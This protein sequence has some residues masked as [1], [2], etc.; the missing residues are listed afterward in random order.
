MS[1][2]ISYAIPTYRNRDSVNKN[3]EEEE[4][5]EGVEKK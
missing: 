5:E 4:L 2:H 3:K 1:L